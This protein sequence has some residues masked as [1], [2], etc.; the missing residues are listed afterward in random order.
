MSAQIDTSNKFQVAAAVNGQ[1]TLHPIDDALHLAAWLVLVADP[2]GERFHEV[3]GAVQA[4]NDI[5]CA[6]M[7][8]RR[9]RLGTLAQA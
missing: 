4:D 2:D 9:P 3:L 5:G 6:L 8:T 1:I 7:P